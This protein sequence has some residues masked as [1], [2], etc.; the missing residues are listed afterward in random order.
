MWDGSRCERLVVARWRCG[1]LWLVATLVFEGIFPVRG[2][3]TS[4]ASLI[5][6]DAGRDGEASNCKAHHLSLAAAETADGIAHEKD[7]GEVLGAESGSAKVLASAVL[8][9]DRNSVARFDSEVWLSGLRGVSATGTLLVIAI[10][11]H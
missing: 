5:Y 11:A 1:G 2:E 8:A 4:T 6:F 7:L 10:G 9:A 3:I